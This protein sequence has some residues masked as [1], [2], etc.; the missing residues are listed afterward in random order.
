MEFGDESLRR[1]GNLHIRHNVWGLD[2]AS[3]S[4]SQD[5][6]VVDDEGT[7]RNV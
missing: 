3:P 1:R 2:T 6:V 7:G 4:Q 5:L